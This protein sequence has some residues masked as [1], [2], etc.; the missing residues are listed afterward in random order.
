MADYVFTLDIVYSKGDR[1]FEKTEDT[2]EDDVFSSDPSDEN[3]EDDVDERIESKHLGSD[4]L[5]VAKNGTKYKHRRN[6]SY[7]LCEV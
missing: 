5:Y 6:P 4:L 3:D 1:L 2:N 7:T